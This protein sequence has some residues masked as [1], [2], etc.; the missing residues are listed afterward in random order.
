MMV[1]ILGR[2]MRYGVRRWSLQVTTGKL[3]RCICDLGHVWVKS[4]LGMCVYIPIMALL[5]RIVDARP[6]TLRMTLS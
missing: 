4:Q 6:L 2:T 3:R 1:E 5:F